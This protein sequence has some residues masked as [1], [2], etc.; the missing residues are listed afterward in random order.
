MKK[1]K[2]DLMHAWFEKAESDLK[3]ISL[4]MKTEESLAQ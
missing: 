1:N 2:D 4:S 3:T